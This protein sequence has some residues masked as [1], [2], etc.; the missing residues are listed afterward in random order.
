MTQTLVLIKP[1]CVERKF[2]PEILQKILNAEFQIVKMKMLTMSR[3]I[4]ETFY[5]IHQEKIFFP[6]LIQDITSGPVIALVLE[7]NDS[8]VIEEWRKFIGNTDPNKATPG[9]LRRMYGLSIGQN[10]IHGSDSTENANREIKI[11]FP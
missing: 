4:A 3:E 6:Q 1:E 7:K 10:G 2:Y 8:D 5:S 9:T 11:I